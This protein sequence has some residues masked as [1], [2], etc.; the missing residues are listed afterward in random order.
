M[1]MEHAECLS[2]C[3][4]R[5]AEAGFE[6][7]LVDTWAHHDLALSVRIR[8]SDGHDVR[9]G[10]CRSRERCLNLYQ[11]ERTQSESEACC[12]KNERR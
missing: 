1:E 6:K 3:S 11:R 12:Q 7:L 8:R 10:G 9:L 4:R 5:R 2:D